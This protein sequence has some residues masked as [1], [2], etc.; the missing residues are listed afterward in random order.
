MILDQEKLTAID[1]NGL[2][3]VLLLLNLTI[4][5]VANGSADPAEADQRLTDLANK[6]DEFAR[7]ATEPRTKLLMSQLA[8]GLM[9]TERTA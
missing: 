1:V 7:K 8:L 4:E 6:I 5:V 3:L 2:D 9:G